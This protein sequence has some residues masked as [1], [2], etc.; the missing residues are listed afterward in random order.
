MRGALALVLIRKRLITQRSLVQIQPPATMNDEGLADVEAASPFR[1]PRL[2]PGSCFVG[3]ALA[4]DAH[5]L[6]DPMNAR[7]M[8]YSI[9]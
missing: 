1:L 7:L 6:L 2:H 5:G 9:T 8:H 3:L 4:P